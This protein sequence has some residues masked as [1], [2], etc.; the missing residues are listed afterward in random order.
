MAADHDTAQKAPDDPRRHKLLEAA[1]TVF[2]RYGFRKASMDEVARAAQVSRQGLYLHFATKEDLF[3]AA[4]QHTLETSLQAAVASLGDAALPVE[5]RLVGG[6]DAWVGRYVGVMGAGASDLAEA[7]AALVGTMVSDH[8]ERFTEAV[9]RVIRASGLLA[10]YK[11]A[12]LTA[13]QLAGTLQATARGLKH[14]CATRAAFV[15]GMTVAARMMCLPL[16][17]SR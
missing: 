5:S 17:G 7:S 11:P 6:F 9:A 1:F 14:G 13:R 3:R 4:L 12:G 8:E 10:A 2:T 15:E 16:G